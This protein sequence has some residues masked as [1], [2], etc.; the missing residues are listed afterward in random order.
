MMASAALEA[1]IPPAF[2]FAIAAKSPTERE[3]RWGFSRIGAE[4][5]PQPRDA[6][7][8]GSGLGGGAMRSQPPLG[9]R[10]LEWE[11]TVCAMIV[12]VGGS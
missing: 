12:V 6:D 3:S 1:I 7:F 8:R 11:R 5:A 4:R 10:E 2:A 9:R